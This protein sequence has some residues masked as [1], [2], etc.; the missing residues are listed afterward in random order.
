MSADDLPDMRCPAVFHHL[1]HWTDRSGIPRTHGIVED[2][3]A[4]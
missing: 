2:W 1:D 3:T 4:S